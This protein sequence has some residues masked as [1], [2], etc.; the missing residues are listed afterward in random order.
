MKA[1]V[2]QVLTWCVLVFPAGASL[3]D[4]DPP[5]DEE[6]EVECAWEAP[7]TGY[8][9]HTE[10]YGVRGINDIIQRLEDNCRASCPMT[11]RQRE[12]LRSAGRAACE[13][14]LRQY[15]ADV[16]LS[17]L[18]E[19][20]F[21]SGDR[22]F[23]QSPAA[24]QLAA[25]VGL[26]LNI[27]LRRTL[28][29]LVSKEWKRIATPQQ[30]QAT[31][32]DLYHPKYGQLSP[33]LYEADSLRR[34][35]RGEFT[36]EDLQRWDIDPRGL[37]DPREL[38]V[39]PGLP[40]ADYWR[41]MVSRFTHRHRLTPE[42]QAAAQAILDDCVQRARALRQRDDPEVQRLWKQ[43]L[44]AYLD[45]KASQVPL[46]EALRQYRR[47]SQEAVRPIYEEMQR[48]LEAILTTEQKRRAGPP[49]PPPEWMRLLEIAL[50]DDDEPPAA[51]RPTTQPTTSPAPTPPAASQP[52]DPPPAPPTTPPSL[53]PATRPADQ[54]A[55]AP[56]AC[57]RPS[58]RREDARLPRPAR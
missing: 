37:R 42:Q 1:T 54:P 40:W 25:I 55:T 43:L 26:R 24:S 50:A 16:M 30:W 21:M 8:E 20:A 7:W 28:T 34:M 39:P 49:P 17:G 12:S 13:R 52:A 5:R 36:E 9:R 56:S 53:P 31:E 18:L 4:Q 3:L 46:H 29:E 47:V 35:A 44:T 11:T 45:P 23:D 27:E 33:K 58:P 57:G 6:A 10:L 48:R 14:L 22:S 19:D 15:Q 51:S 2:T 38:P 41:F 32:D